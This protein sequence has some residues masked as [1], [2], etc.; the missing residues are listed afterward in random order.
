MNSVDS[1]KE[2]ENNLVSVLEKMYI[3]E[4]ISEEFLSIYFKNEEIIYFLKK[5]V[6]KNKTIIG[7]NDSE[8]YEFNKILNLE[9][10]NSSIKSFDAL[11]EAARNFILVKKMKKMNL[12]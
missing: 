2:L 3:K 9:N 5:L 8:K 11:I 12:L 1:K 7:I 6:D 4:L 10:N